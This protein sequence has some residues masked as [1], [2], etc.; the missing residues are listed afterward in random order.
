MHAQRD[1]GDRR[2]RSTVG[3][4]SRRVRSTGAWPRRR[5]P[6][7]L[8]L[9]PYFDGERTPNLPKSTGLLA[10]LRSDVSREQLARAAVEGVVCG[11][12]DALDA[13]GAQAPLERGPAGRRRRT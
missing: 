8:T 4:R 12:L 11:L 13:L 10:G 9:L 1:Q 5:A 2:D 3:C 6:A 7:A